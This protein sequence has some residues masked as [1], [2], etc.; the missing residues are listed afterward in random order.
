M[1]TI[2]PGTIMQDYSSVGASMVINKKI[3]KGFCYTNNSMRKRNLKQFIR[4]H[5]EIKKYFK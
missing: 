2:L 1:T 5:T 3:L 4:L